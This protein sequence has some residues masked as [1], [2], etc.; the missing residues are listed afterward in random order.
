MNIK[1]DYN[2]ATKNQTKGHSFII[3]IVIII[4]LVLCIKFSWWFA[5]LGWFLI[6]FI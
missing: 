4:T 1:E 2:K 6:M 3:M 5:L